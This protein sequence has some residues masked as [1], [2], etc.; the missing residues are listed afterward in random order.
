MPAM[1]PAL[2]RMLVEDK[3]QTAARR[4][5]HLRFREAQQALDAVP[6]P[7]AVVEG[8]RPGPSSRRRR[9]SASVSLRRTSTLPIKASPRTRT[10]GLDASSRVG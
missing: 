4:R 9:F 3:Q 1:T 8:Q 5:E 2:A 10:A 7:G 6:P